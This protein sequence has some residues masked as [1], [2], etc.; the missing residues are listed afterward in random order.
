ME[1]PQY[2][3]YKNEM[4]YFKI[5]DRNS[6][7]EWKKYGKGWEKIE[8]KVK[9]LPDRNYLS[10]MLEEDSL[11]WDKVSAEEFNRFM[12]QVQSFDS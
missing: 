11:Y 4:S 8:I 5:P 10:D 2:R 9:I 1:F 12:L 7:T 3:K 6:F